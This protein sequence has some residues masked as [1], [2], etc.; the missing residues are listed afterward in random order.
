MKT[1]HTLLK[2]MNNFSGAGEQKSKN[3][4]IYNKLSKRACLA[5][6]KVLND[7]GNALEAVKQAVIS[8]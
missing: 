4:A 1:P 2:I 8:K 7:S 5:G 6:I 3:Y